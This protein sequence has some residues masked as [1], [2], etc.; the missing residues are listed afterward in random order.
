MSVGE[1]KTEFS[2]VI[3]DSV[4][5][6]VKNDNCTVVITKNENAVSN[7]GIETIR[8]TPCHRE[9]ADER[10]FLRVN[11]PSNLG[12]KKVT[13]AIVDTDV[14]LLASYAFWFLEI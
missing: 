13:V 9:K 2:S 4:T 11:E 7:K 6:N 1:N 5:N 8:V 14:V 3:V 12:R 10:M